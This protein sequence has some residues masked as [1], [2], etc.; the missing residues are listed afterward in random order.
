MTAQS[1]SPQDRLHYLDWVR[2]AAF[3]LLILYH[4]GMFY[5]TWG[6]HVKSPHAGHALEPLMQITSPWRLTLLFL[7]SGA[8]TRF[9]AAKSTPGALA[10]SRLGRLLLPLLFGMAVIVPPQSYFE[11]V[12]KLGY[13]GGYLAFWA[14][15]L[16][17]DAGFTVDGARLILPTWNHLWFVAYILVYSLLLAGLLATARPLLARLE[18]GLA[19]LLSGPGALIWPILYLAVLRAVLLPRFGVT[20][21]LVDDW[22]THAVSLSAFVTGFCLAGAPAIGQTFER[23]RWPALA[24]ALCAYGLFASYAWI[25]RAPDAV[26]PEMLVLAMRPVYAAQQWG[27]IVAALGFARRHLNR[28]SPQLR[29]CVEAVFPWYI[30]HQTLIVVAGHH[31]AQL[32]LTPLAEGGLL[33][34]VTLGGTALAGEMVRR[35]GPLRPLFGLKRRPTPRGSRGLC[36]QPERIG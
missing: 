26:P 13:T 12:E 7:V 20:H 15:Y 33:L 31:L 2:V 5:V 10:R 29:Y 11:V 36:P 27:A 30:V 19:R 24:I 3:A 8:A 28:P 25:Y 14:R 32:H 22:Y 1:F 34:A 23:L 21:A 6:W 18:R 16:Q 17:F 35:T 9:M 4:E